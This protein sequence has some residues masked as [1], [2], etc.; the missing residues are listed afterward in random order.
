MVHSSF[1]G[2]NIRLVEEV[3]EIIVFLVR[4]EVL[5]VEEDAGNPGGSGTPGQGNNGGNGAP[6]PGPN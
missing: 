3:Q 5:E 4:A 6:E 2:H 1:N